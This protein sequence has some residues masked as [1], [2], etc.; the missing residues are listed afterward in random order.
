MALD[1]TGFTPK[2][3]PEII[4]E[5]NNTL[6]TLSAADVDTSENSFIGHLHSNFALALNQLWELAQNVY[7][8][9]DIYNAEGASL[10]NLALLFGIVRE[11]ASRTNGTAFF[12]GRDG[13]NI[14]AGAR[15]AS[16]KGDQFEVV[17]QFAI[18]SLDCV[19][20]RVKPE[21]VL[22]DT[23]YILIVDDVTYTVSS[24][25][26]ATSEEI[27]DD[28]DLA[29]QADGSITTTKVIDSQDDTKSYLLISR[30]DKSST[31]SITGSTYFSY[32][33]VIS[34]SEV[35]A[36]EYGRIAGEAYAVK[37]ILSGVTGWYNVYN[38]NDLT[39]G[40]IVQTDAQL[41]NSIYTAFKTVG[42][43]TYDS[44]GAK[45]K[46]V[47]GV[48]TVYIR[49]NN[50]ITTD[51]NSVPPLSYEVIVN[52]GLDKEVASAIW[53]TKPIAKQTHGNESV[54]I[55][56][57]NG[58]NQTVKFTRPTEKYIFIDVRYSPY[59]EELLP[60]GA[61]DN[62]KEAIKAYADNNLTINT[63]VIAKR[64]LGSIYNASTGFGDITVKVASSVSP[65]TIP[66]YPADYTDVIEISDAE[67]TSFSVTRMNFTE[68]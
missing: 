40:K 20:L 51:G 1:S 62:A 15:V 44:I 59:T 35:R 34:P 37:K 36:I 66:S 30:D 46:S 18:S 23:D 38:P 2:R 47:E 4:T 17:N 65:Q 31:M 53:Q 58:F 14:P 63:D 26:S 67:I 61:I 56:D 13:T 7:S 55:K 6:K 28:L 16:I 52:G 33:N 39:S 5:L 41:R 50:T 22:G 49:E 64:F 27:I 60:N 11:Q 3:Y 12:V 21:I 32:D 24:D 42:S 9:T 54:T 45:V 68:V 57:F 8:S 25:S 19:E 43:G 29:L 10:D 48:D